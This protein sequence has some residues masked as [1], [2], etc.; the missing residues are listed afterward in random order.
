M[1]AIIHTIYALK[2]L[3]AGEYTLSQKEQ[4]DFLTY[5]D[6]CNAFQHTLHNLSTVY[7]AA[8]YNHKKE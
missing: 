1:G 5:L 4:G 6:T 2:M 8:S 7:R 3:L